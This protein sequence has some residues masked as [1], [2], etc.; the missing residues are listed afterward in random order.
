MQSIGRPLIL[1]T[2]LLLM[3]AAPANLCHELADLNVTYAKQ[4][5]QLDAAITKQQGIP[6]D[7]TQSIRVINLRRQQIVFSLLREAEAGGSQIGQGCCTE[8]F[9]DQVNRWICVTTS[10]LKD[11]DSSKLIQG[12]PMD[13]GGIDALFEL[14]A[15][16]GFAP[17][18]KPLEVPKT[19]RGQSFSGYT[20]ERIYERVLEKDEI[21]MSRF[22]SL[23]ANPSSE[24]EGLEEM[25]AQLLIRYPEVVLAQWPIIKTHEKRIHVATT[26]FAS[27]SSDVLQRYA[28]K[29][30]Q[31]GLS[32]QECTKIQ[33]FLKRLAAER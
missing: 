33:E 9:N 31:Q 4:K 12:M 23:L 27:S 14:D 5:K 8:K 11:R 17:P 29:C 2:V 28:E 10:Y 6:A 18:D 1:L 30:K 7:L 16:L 32:S 13:H 15:I 24:S 3:G 21:A 25:F 19:F 22:L 20:I 26:D